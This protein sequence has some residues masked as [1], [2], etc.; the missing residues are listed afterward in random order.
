VHSVI[1][2]PIAQCRLRGI[3][4]SPF[5][6]SLLQ[7]EFVFDTYAL[8]V[9]VYYQVFDEDYDKMLETR[10][11]IYPNSPY[12]GRCDVTRI[13]LPHRVGSLVKSICNREGQP[14]GM[15][16]DR[17]E[18]HSTILYPSISSP[19]SSKFNLRDDLDLLSELRPG[20]TPEEPV[21]LRVRCDGTSNII[22]S[23]YLD[24]APVDLGEVLWRGRRWDLSTSTNSH[25]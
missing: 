12:I 6:V 9:S 8:P 2:S 19:N 13:P 5:T 1:L 7:V 14:Y 23:T 15:D 3:G 18:G 25:S 16:F 24:S 20:S 4:Y 22:L 17:D 10:H 11:P 21:L